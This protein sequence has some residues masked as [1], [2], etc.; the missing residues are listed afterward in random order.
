MKVLTAALAALL[1][2]AICS[3]IAS[4]S[5]TTE[6]PSLCCFKYMQRRVPLRMVASAYRVSGTC[7][8]PAIVLVTKRG[9][10]VCTD[11]KAP[12]VQAYLRHFQ[13]PQK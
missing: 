5:E 1:L 12:W 6:V 13:S 9:A 7:S 2:L 11:P 8:L 4:S 3:G 10:Q